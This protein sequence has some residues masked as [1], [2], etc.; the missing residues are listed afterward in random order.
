MLE[1]KNPNSKI[2]RQLKVLDVE[3]NEL[4][5]LSRLY[6]ED[7]IS[8]DFNQK[9][10]IK[11]NKENLKQI[12]TTMINKEFMLPYGY[13]QILLYELLGKI[14][15]FYTEDV[16]LPITDQASCYWALADD[17][18]GAVRQ[19]GNKL[20][21]NPEIYD[22]TFGL[23]LEVNYQGNIVYGYVNSTLLGRGVSGIDSAEDV[24]YELI[25]NIPSYLEKDYNL[26]VLSGATYSIVGEN[27]A[28]A[29]IENN[30]IKISKLEGEGDGRITLRVEYKRGNDTAS[31]DMY[32]TVEKQY[33]FESFN[34]EFERSKGSQSEINFNIESNNNKPLYVEVTGDRSKFTISR[35]NNNS[36]NVEI[37][38]NDK[39]T[40]YNSNKYGTEEFVITVN[41]YSN[42][43]KLTLY[44]TENVII[45]Y[46]YGP[47]YTL[48]KTEEII[49]ENDDNGYAI[50]NIYS[51][52]GEAIYANVSKPNEL[53]NIDIF[54]SDEEYLI[55]VVSVDADKMNSNSGS[56]NEYNFEVTIYSD[57]EYKNI[58][59]TVEY[60]INYIFSPTDPID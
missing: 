27:E 26:P 18:L 43:Q 5:E 16:E 48:D 41:I 21:F 33:S 57:N 38:I 49:Q 19:E 51:E 35:K 23:R 11:I 50:F 34:Y 52:T 12:I 58:L 42:N 44:G 30:T 36:S 45:S 4:G 39:D 24:L 55:L 25:K 40:L 31:I 15:N 28:D 9:E 60:T 59:G 7:K 32:I 56:V 20:I 2:I 53:F 47:A 54:N 13:A 6:V 37:S 46:Y 17:Y 1:F 22:V 29:I 10:L 8:D 14:E 3:R